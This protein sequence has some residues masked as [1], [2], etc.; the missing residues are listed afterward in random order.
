MFVIE[1]DSLEQ[2]DAQRLSNPTDTKELIKTY[3]LN[4]SQLVFTICELSE[5]EKLWTKFRVSTVYA[6]VMTG[7]M[8]APASTTV[9]CRWAPQ[10]GSWEGHTEILIVF[11]QIDG[12]RGSLFYWTL[13]VR[14]N[15]RNSRL[16]LSSLHDLYG[17]RAVWSNRTYSSPIHWKRHHFIVHSSMS[18]E[19]STWKQFAGSGHCHSTGWYRDR[20]DE[21]HLHSTYE[22]VLLSIALLVLLST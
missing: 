7:T 21:L 20:S 12:R 15:G 13:L 5:N 17:T 3:Q 9:G 14:V 10:R 19:L 8:P 16:F 11:P 1:G 22:D 6:D 2:L 18:R 4:Q